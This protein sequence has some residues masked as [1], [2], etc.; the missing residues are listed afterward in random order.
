MVEY[1]CRQSTERPMRRQSA[2]KTSSSSRVSWRQSSMK[3]GRDTTRG[4]P[5]SS[6][7]VGGAR[8]SPGTLGAFGSQR[9]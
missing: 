6:A 9:T 7:A 4:G 8:R 5:F 3:S 2:L 1:S